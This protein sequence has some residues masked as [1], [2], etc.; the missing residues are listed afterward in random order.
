M[1][2][3]NIGIIGEGIISSVADDIFASK[4]EFAWSAKCSSIKKLCAKK[5]FFNSIFDIKRI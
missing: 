1:T 4:T 2:V 5:L 3:V